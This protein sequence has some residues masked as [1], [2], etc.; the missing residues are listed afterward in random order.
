[1]AAYGRCDLFRDPTATGEEEARELVA[2]LERRGRLPDERETRAAYLGLLGIGP[3]QRV[4]DVGC[5]SGVVTRD[6]AR[7]VAPGGLAVGLDP[8]P[9]FLTHAGALARADGLR[10]GIE[11]QLGGA[12][13]IPFPDG[14]FDAVVAATVLAHVPD[15]ARAVPELGRVTRPGGRVGVFDLDTDSLVLAHPDRALT[16]RI[17]AAHS[18][19]GAVDGW[20][21]R[22]LPGLFL[23]AGF[24][25]VGVRAFT[26]LDRDPSGFYGGTA[27]RAA[28]VAVKVGAIDEAEREGWLVALRAQQAAGGFLAGRTHLFVW[29]TRPGAGGGRS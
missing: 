23:Q 11:F 19:H 28:E 14:S 12:L 2:R 17:V 27:E 18:D 16:R 26:P 21:A 29:G 10:D 7:R 5:G 20:L 3:G 25:E 6:L 22:R 24:E 15:G 4:L 9:T 13:A 1:V 8:S